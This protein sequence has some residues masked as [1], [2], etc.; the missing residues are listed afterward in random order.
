MDQVGVNWMRKDRG[1]N[2][3]DE[4]EGGSNPKQI[5]LQGMSII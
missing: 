5:L 4:E 3:M 2:G 1:K